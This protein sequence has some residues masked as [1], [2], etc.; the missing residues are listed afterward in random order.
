MDRRVVSDQKKTKL[1]II[2]ALRV[3]GSTSRIMLTQLTGLSRATI[4]MAIS[5]LME[6]G[7]IRETDKVPSTGGR[8]ATVLQLVPHSQLIVGADLDNR[9]WTIGAFDLLGNVVDMKKVP[10]NAYLVDETFNILSQELKSFIHH[11]D[12][13]PLPVLG[14]GVPGYID[15][16][17]RIIKTA[18]EPEL[19]WYDL[20]VSDRLEKELG[21]PTVLLNRHRARGLAECRFGSGQDLQNMIYIGVGTG[22]RAGIY[23]DRQLITGSLLGAGELGHT[24]IEPNGPLCTCGNQGCLQTLCSAASIEQEGRRL[25]RLGE[26][27]ILYSDRMGDLQRLQ[28]TDVCVAADAGDELSIQVI[29]KAAQYM[30]IAM[31]NLVNILNPEGIILGGSI[32]VASR[33]FIETATRTMQQRAMNV[34]S[35]GTIVKAAQLKDEGGALGAANF[36]L[37]RNMT[38]DFFEYV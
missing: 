35:S 10:V 12:K 11:L 26:P 24:T 20:E 21:W 23:M 6:L 16:D 1:N 36:A 27:S 2:Q 25:L 19:G 38:N 28:A 31:A 17:H 32:P 9:A 7:L 29:Q 33:L 34:L 37:D 14:I 4:S 5:E 13:S 8:P 22:L 3:Y 30:G 18:P 15:K